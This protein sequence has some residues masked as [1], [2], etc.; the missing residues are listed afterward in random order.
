VAQRI[1]ESEAR[2]R[3][4]LRCQVPAGAVRRWLRGD[5]PLPRSGAARGRERW[6]AGESGGG[7]GRLQP[8]AESGAPAHLSENQLF[9]LF[10][11]SKIT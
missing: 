3:G 6:G 5:L 9:F 2:V 10:F 8:W 7:P 11:K 4:P 1:L